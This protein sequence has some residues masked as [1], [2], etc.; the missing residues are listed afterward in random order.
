M[1]YTRLSK[2]HGFIERNGSLQLGCSTTS[3]GYD[4]YSVGVIVD[5]IPA[6]LIGNY[7]ANTQRVVNV[8]RSSLTE[9]ITGEGHIIP[10]TSNG[11]YA[12][13]SGRKL[14]FKFNVKYN[15]TNKDLQGNMNVIFRRGSN[16]YQIKAT[17]MNSLLIHSIDPCSKKAIFTS[18]ANLQD[19][20]N[21][22]ISPVSI[23][24]GITLQITMKDNGEPANTDK[25]GITLLNGNSLVYSSNWVSTQTIEM[26][27]NGGNLEVHNGVHCSSI[28]TAAITYDATTKFGILNPEPFKVIVSPNP[29]A[30]DFRIKV[31]GTSNDPINIRVTDALSRVITTITRV[32]KNSV[33]TL[34]G[35]YRGGTYFVE[36]TQGKN[37]KQLKLIKL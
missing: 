32:Q 17:A 11:E 16:V 4:V 14:N 15:K 37:K 18:K 29:F 20:T 33:V 31:E 13:D 23:Y 9:F 3:H 1:A 19:I 26:S 36:V 12:S 28:T 35:N 22:D 10:N 8:S 24:G 34:S 7:T 5:N 27:L 6:T 21:P 25:I 2:P 30:T